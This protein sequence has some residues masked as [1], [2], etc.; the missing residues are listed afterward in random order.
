MASK[1]E[2]QNVIDS[3]D[4]VSLVSEYVKLDKQGKNYKGLCPF[5]HEDTPSFIVSPEK[6]YAKC[7]GCGN[8][9]NPIDFLI[10]IE[11]IDF[12]TAL[13][14]L[15]KKNG[16]KLSDS[17]FTEKA[18]PLMKY[19][20]IMNTSLAFYQK[21]L[22]N[23]KEGLEALEYM[24][25][26]GLDDETI[27]MFGIGL[28]PSSH[29]SLYQVLKDA[30]D[31]ELDMID[32]ALVDKGQFGYYD[33]FTKRIMFPIKNEIG[34]VIGYSG[35]IFNN[36]DKN[37]PKYV[38]SRE[39][40]LFKKHDVLYNL[41]LAKSEIQKKKR[42][43]LHEGQMDVIASFRSGLKEAICTMGTALSIDQI[44]VLKKYT[45]HAIIC[46]DNDKAG[47][48]ASLKA[49]ELFQKAGFLVHLVLLPEGIKDADEFVLSKG[50]EEY[51]KYFESNIVDSYTYIFNQAFI[52]KNLNDSEAVLQIKNQIFEMIY[53]SKTK[54]NEELYLNK[55]SEK[56]NCS[57]DAI[58][59]DYVSYCNIN[60]R[61][62]TVEEYNENNYNYFENYSPKNIKKETFLSPCEMRLFMYAR[63]SKEKA[64][65]IDRMLTDRIE[66]MSSSA[67]RLWISLIN[68][69]YENFDEFEEGKFVKI[70]DT[71]NFQYYCKIVELL[72]KDKVPY[73]DE[74]L[75]DCLEKLK[76]NKIDID[77][78]ELNDRIKR[79]DDISKRVL[80]VEMKF[81]N[82][83]KKEKL[84]EQ[85]R[86]K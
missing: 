52:N 78:D 45:N 2:I 29:D 79:T 74:D 28:A 17:G 38:N 16:I 37:Q 70:L 80:S 84:V 30:G 83:K 72:S 14:K 21:Y 32:V 24:H 56:L 26:R 59:S 23:T 25:K 27:R 3:T 20:Q 61:E 9:G 5:H 71:E 86:R 11:N 66:A 73:S 15:A 39:T 81:K 47:I 57:F 13:H 40:I 19:Y 58:Y 8:G 67:Q 63:A 77:N 42:V 22:E 51:V 62:K 82:I 12:N 36:T 55:L 4:I 10:K 64:L 43:I 33:L 46:Y 69:Y 35:R 53:I 6:K 75:N 48:N 65:F 60:H 1:T 34:N 49:I 85:T 41:N 50:S 18:N 76:R 31:L 7:F 54:T 44:N 68:T